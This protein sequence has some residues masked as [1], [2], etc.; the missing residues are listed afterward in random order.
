MTDDKTEMIKMLSLAIRAITKG[1]DC[2]IQIN[3]KE[4][5]FC[6]IGICRE[7]NE[8]FFSYMD[9]DSFETVIENIKKELK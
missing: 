8:K 9:W 6:K 2:E 7:V 5:R 4:K 3:T 1:I